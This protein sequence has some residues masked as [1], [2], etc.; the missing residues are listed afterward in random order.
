M[1]HSDYFNKTICSP[2]SCFVM[3][4]GGRNLV[5]RKDIEVNFNRIQVNCQ[6]SSYC[7]VHENTNGKLTKVQFEDR[8]N[9]TK[10]Q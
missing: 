7:L 10:S 9:V 2:L 4:V 8:S 5:E 3:F 1:L 6:K